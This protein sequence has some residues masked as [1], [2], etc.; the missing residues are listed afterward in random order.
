[1]K[2]LVLAS[3]VLVLTACAT[4][5]KTDIVSQINQEMACY[6]SAAGGSAAEDWARGYILVQ[7]RAGLSDD[8]FDEIVRGKGGRSLGR[9]ANLPIH[10]IA[11]PENAEDA[12]VRALSKNPSIK[13]AEKDM[14]VAPDEFIPN[15]P[16]YSEAW[17]L[18]T[19]QAPA[20]WD[21]A[22]GDGIV[23]AVLDT[24][25]YGAHPD[26]SSKMV[27]GWN[28]PSGNTDTADIHGH[29]TAVAGFAGADTN[30]AIGISSVGFNTQIMPIRITN[31]TDGA[32]YFSDIAKGVNWAISNGAKVANISFEVVSSS[33]V[34]TAAQDMRTKGGVVISGSGNSNIDLGYSD[35]PYIIVAAATTSS[36]TRASFSNYGNYVDISAPGANVLTT[37]RSGSYSSWNGT[38]FSS[39]ITAGV[40]ALVMS[41][42]P[43]LSPD[44]VEQVLE[45]SADDLVQGVDW[46]AYYGHGRVNAAKAVQLALNTS[47]EDTETPKVTIFSQLP[48]DVVS[49]DVLVEVSAT[50]NTGVNEVSLYINGVL[51]ASDIVTPYQFNWDSTQEVDGFVTLT[52]KAS[53]SALNEGVSAEISVEVKNAPAVDDFTAPEI[54]INN[55]VDG[56]ILVRT[57]N[58]S[59]TAV[60]NIEVAET[61]LFID[62]SLVTSIVGG[63][64]SYSWNTR[65]IADGEYSISASAVDTS[66]NV[67]DSSVI[68]VTKGGIDTTET[69]TKPVRGKKK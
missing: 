31:R 1:M 17:H 3:S 44:Q 57:V 69:S 7:P 45:S 12:V 16:R 13:F 67:V 59:V 62:G 21:L 61:Q 8:K 28:I 22:Q 63:D 2:K 14:L 46:H 52:A 25:V 18:A 55:P 56:G 42:N 11:V 20:A 51:L 38:S 50:D 10:K 41:A 37:N 39:P 49:G 4:T 27:A 54:M 32:A 19:I 29:G 6:P 66:G 30:N 43:S 68:I 48:N 33:T 15:D 34:K 47:A 36:D 64:L 9:L 5:Q 58:I 26:L 53:D 23:I 40:A 60:D 35:N 24:G 65:K